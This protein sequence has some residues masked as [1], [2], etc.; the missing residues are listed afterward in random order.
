[1]KKHTACAAVLGALVL[2]L[3]H[4]G[5]A[6]YVHTPN[7]E[8]GEREIELV[9]GAQRGGGAE[10][11]D[12]ALLL[13]GMGVTQRWFTEVGVEFARGADSGTKLEAVEWENI[14]QLTERGQY[15]VDLGLL[16]EIERPQDR[17]EGYELKVG[18]LFQTEFGRVQLNGNLIFERH[19][20]AK[21]K[22]ET[23]LAYEWQA[24]YR[25]KPALEFGAMGFGELG[26]WDNWAPHR[27]QSH[28]MGPAVFG[29]IHTGERQ[30]VK[31]NAAYLVGVTDGAADHAVRLQL[32]YEF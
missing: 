22:S 6:N 25:W 23:E 32:E 28:L 29:K 21:E 13:F 16:V 10:R 11:E 9:L 27:E 17:D 7:V 8:Y 15:P 19:F 26:K 12:A 30:A 4:A 3:A 24:K 1:M 2:P 14:F 31:Y 18:P 20:D 5:P